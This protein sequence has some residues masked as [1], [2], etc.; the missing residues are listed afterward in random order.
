M[1]IFDGVHILSSSTVCKVFS[2]FDNAI[3]SWL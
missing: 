2:N 1:T 3:T